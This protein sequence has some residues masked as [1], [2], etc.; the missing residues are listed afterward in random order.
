MINFYHIPYECAICHLKSIWCGK[1]L[2]LQVDHINGDHSDC[3]IENLRFLCPNCHSQT[4]TW[5][6]RKLKH[7]DK[8]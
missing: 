1:Q 4:A 5:S 3:R 8:K 7:H 6:G 2:V